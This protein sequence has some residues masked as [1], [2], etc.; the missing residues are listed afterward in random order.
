MT[1]KID[2]EDNTV[3]L[4]VTIEKD[5]RDRVRKLAAAK[6]IRVGKLVAQILEH[7]LLTLSTTPPTE[8]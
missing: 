7:C 2:V 3:P 6:G 8:G 1:F 5:L 4:T